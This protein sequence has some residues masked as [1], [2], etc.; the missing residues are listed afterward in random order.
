MASKVVHPPKPW[1]SNIQMVVASL[2]GF[3]SVSGAVI[4]YFVA[5]ANDRRDIKEVQEEVSKLSEENADQEQDI[6]TADKNYAI[7]QQQLG[8]ISDSLKDLKTKR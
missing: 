4:G 2:V 8:V 5:Q 6:Q 3:I 1:Y 7:I